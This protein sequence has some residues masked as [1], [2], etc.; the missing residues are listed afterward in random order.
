MQDF[1]V[2]RTEGT[3]CITTWRHPILSSEM[4]FD[5]WLGA[6]KSHGLQPPEAAP[7]QPGTGPPQDDRPGVRVEGQSDDTIVGISSMIPAA[8]VP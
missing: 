3:H 4:S 6:V 2:K 5:T 7:Q 1:P 8:V